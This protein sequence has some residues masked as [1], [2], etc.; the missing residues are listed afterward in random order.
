MSKWCGIDGEDVTINCWVANHPIVEDHLYVDGSWVIT[1]CPPLTEM[2]YT[3]TPESRREIVT[4]MK[5]S[6]LNPDTPFEYLPGCIQDNGE[7]GFILRPG[8]TVIRDNTGKFG[9][10]E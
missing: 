10:R 2:T 9:I 4:W 6:A 5:A 1:R 7:P 3:G 8:M